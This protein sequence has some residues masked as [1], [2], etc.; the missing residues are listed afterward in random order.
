MFVIVNVLFM[1]LFCVGGFFFLGFVFDL[2]N[3]L[4]SNVEKTKS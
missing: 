3:D 4:I 2:F 1:Y